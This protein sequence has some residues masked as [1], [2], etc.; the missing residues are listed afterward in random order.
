M[1]NVD[2]FDY[3]KMLTELFFTDTNCKL[4][5]NGCGPGI[6]CSMDLREM[7]EKV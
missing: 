1:E 4:C 2:N 6:N 5:N 3:K 7:A